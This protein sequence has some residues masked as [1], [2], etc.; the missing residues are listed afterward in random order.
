M[1][2]KFKNPFYTCTWAIVICAVLCPPAM[3]DETTA[4]QPTYALLLQSSPAGAGQVAPGNGV[5]KINIGQTITL[6]AAPR[7]G[8]R[9]LYWLGDVSASGLLETTVQLDSPK[10]VIAVFERNSFEDLHDVELISGTSIGGLHG[11]PASVGSGSGISGGSYP[12]PSYSYP[13]STPAE[14]PKSD[15]FPVPEEDFPVPD[16]Q[17]IPEPATILVLGLGTWL[18]RAPRRKNKILMEHM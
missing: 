5:H 17:P 1:C 6:T 7:Q 15:D 4:G 18:I 3:A 14:N 16:E 13:S 8:Y 10:L 11:N 12:N 9:F 2:L